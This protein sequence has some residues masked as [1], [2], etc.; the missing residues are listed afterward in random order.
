MLRSHAPSHVPLAEA[1]PFGRALG[2]MPIG[3]QDTPSTG[4]FTQVP[5][6]SHT[7]LWPSALSEV[8]QHGEAVTF[9]CEFNFEAIVPSPSVVEDAIDRWKE[10]MLPGCDSRASTSKLNDAKKQSETQESA[11]SL[12]LGHIK[13]VNPDAPLVGADE[14][15]SLNVSSGL[16][17]IVAP[18]PWGV[19]HALTSLEQLL[20]TTA[21]PATIL[22][23]VVTDAPTYKHRGVMLDP[24]RNFLPI[25][26][27]QKVV[28]GLSKL[29]L[30]VLH[31]D[32]INAPS[33]PF[34]A[35][36][37]PEFARAGAYPGMNYTAA[38]LK[39]LVGYGA[40]RGVLVLIEVDTP[41][42]SFS[43]GLARPELTTCDQVADQRGKNCPEPPCGYMEMRSQAAM[44][45]TIDVIGDVMDLYSSDAFVELLGGNVPVHL[46][47]DEVSDWCFG[48]NETKPLFRKWVGGLKA[49]TAARGR[50]TVTWMESWSAMGAPLEPADSTLQFWGNAAVWP[51]TEALEEQRAQMQRALDAGFPVIY[52]NASEWYLD[53]GAGNFLNG[54]TSWCDPYKSWQVVLAGDPRRHVEEAQKAQVVGGEVCLWGEQ[55]DPSNLEQKLWQRAA[56]VAER[57]WAPAETLAGC[58]MPVDLPLSGCWKTAQ[59]RLR[60]LEVRLR[61]GG[62]AIAPSQPL[63]CTLAPEMCDAYH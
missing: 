27:L 36:S 44:N 37:H 9:S 54:D 41:G 32:L 1:C 21:H 17:S 62:F 12:R 47:A 56:A 34:E 24:A 30:N 26:L 6:S 57:L 46:G 18:S 5:S 28:N 7:L 4:R 19:M 50:P 13:I 38:D 31:L 29:K 59:D 16:V 63:Y 23:T 60:L 11:N 55:T 48:E 43:W 42:H 53:C 33:F 61:A 15:Y 45:A 35:P 2:P 52:S 20:N 22:P 58:Q 39:A 25:P 51:D 40:A 10:S 3:C 8:R 14:S 49:A